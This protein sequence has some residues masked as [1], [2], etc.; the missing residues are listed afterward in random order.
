MR[1][2]HI[3]S[4][5]QLHKAFQWAQG[6]LR[7]DWTQTS[8]TWIAN[9]SNPSPPPHLAQD[10]MK[11]IAA[12]RNTESTEFLPAAFYLLCVFG[13]WAGVTPNGPSIAQDDLI[14][15]LKGSQ[16]LAR[17]WGRTRA[18][19]GA[20][21]DYDFSPSAREAQ[22]WGEFVAN[23]TT[24]TTV[25]NAMGFTTSPVLPQL[26]MALN[27]ESLKTMS[28]DLKEVVVRD[29]KRH[30]ELY[31]EGGHVVLALGPIPTLLRVQRAML[32][33]QSE[34]FRDM[35]G[36]PLPREDGSETSVEGLS[37]DNPVFLP[38]DPKEFACAVKVY[39]QH[40][41]TPLPE[42]P[43]FDFVMG[44]LRIASKYYFHRASEWAFGTLRADW[45]RTSSTW[46]GHLTNPTPPPDLGQNAL[47][48][49][50]AS[51]IAGSTEFLP[52][53]F[54]FLCVFDNW[55]NVAPGD[56]MLS[57][58]DF[59][60]LLKGSRCLTKT[61]G[62]WRSQRQLEYGYIP[63]YEAQWWKEFIADNTTIT[64]VLPS[65]GFA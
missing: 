24:I 32:V 16:C 44:V 27:P 47:K 40:M 61:W 52:V 53:A 41:L 55:S 21:N 34:I 2:L 17:A 50:L 9:C 8:P 29:A 19:Y 48:L 1:V 62:S 58:D 11:L 36:I 31:F 65:M 59:I 18:Q 51:R 35:L 43:D 25:L 64:A 14:I 5:Y 13:N 30:E 60:I 15:I 38:D 10:A 3:S 26:A 45:A 20:S 23:S 56:P 46:Q 42:K 4:R 7:A 33:T 57:Q 22:W 6:T 54:Y 28:T 49:I 37:D 39:Y 63:E 12:S